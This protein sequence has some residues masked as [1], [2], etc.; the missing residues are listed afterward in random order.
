MSYIPDLSNLNDV[1]KYWIGYFR[2]DGS[3]YQTTFGRT[4]RFAQVHRQPVLEFVRYLGLSDLRCL[5]GNYTATLPQNK[6]K[7]SYTCSYASSKAIGVVY[8]KLGVKEK[9][10]DDRLYQD[11]H[12]WRG[13]IDGDGCIH[14]MPSRNDAPLLIFAGSLADTE[15]FSL[16]CKQIAGQQPAVRLHSSKSIYESRVSG[17]RAR[18]I[19]RVMYRGQYSALEHKRLLAERVIAQE[20]RDCY[21]HSKLEALSCLS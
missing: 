20:Y 2:A 13:M 15:Q 12:F 8:D 5:T 18:L 14:L 16:F 3:I 4:A 1:D 10:Q 19:C 11:R 6:S 17:D 21:R 7:K 9:L